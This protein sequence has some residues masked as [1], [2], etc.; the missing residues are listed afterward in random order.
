M[1]P[2]TSFRWVYDMD[3]AK[4]NIAASLILMALAVFYSYQIGS[5]PDRS[6]MPNTPGPSFFPILIA[7]S[8]F[9]L[10]FALLMSG[11]VEFAQKKSSGAGEK[12]LT[13]NAVWTLLTFLFALIALPYAGFV[14]TS[15]PVFAILMF[16][17]GCRDKMMIAVSSIIVP[18]TLFVVFRFVFQIN[19]PHGLL[20]F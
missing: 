19:L 11:I 4:K 5:L 14:L 3:M 8:L 15:V 9:V 18:I 2:V 20:V 12:F 1:A 17:Y 10:S 13:R 6:A 7:T 16:L